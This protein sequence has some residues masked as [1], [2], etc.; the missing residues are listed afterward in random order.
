MKWWK[1][2]LWPAGR[3]L[4][5]SNITITYL[6]LMSWEGH[7]HCLWT[8]WRSTL[9]AGT[10]N[11]IC[12]CEYRITRNS[13]FSQQKWTDVKSCWF[14]CVA[15]S[16][17][18]N[19]AEC[20]PSQM[21]FCVRRSFKI[22]PH[23]SLSESLLRRRALHVNRS[24]VGF[25]PHRTLFL[26][27]PTARLCTCRCGFHLCYLPVLTWKE[28]WALRQPSSSEGASREHAWFK[29]EHKWRQFPAKPAARLSRRE[30]LRLIHSN[31]CSLSEERHHAETVI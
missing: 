10:Q 27:I 31:S 29:R 9:I 21:C 28:K 1:A 2:P 15:A 22:L 16:L 18:P 20:Y 24:G 3:G 17:Q 30:W 19:T 23:L 5:W 13:R 6:L 26:K 7:C 11:L 25:T 14:F 4:Q 8:L 12:M